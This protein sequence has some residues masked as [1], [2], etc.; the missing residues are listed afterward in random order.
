MIAT[1]RLTKR[2]GTR[3]ALDS[4]TFAAPDGAITG[5]L[6][7]NGAGKTTTF[8]I[9]SGL[10]RADEG[11]VEIGDRER[12]RRHDSWCPAPRPRTLRPPDGSGAHQLLRRAAWHAGKTFLPRELAQLVDQLGLSD[13]ALT[14]QRARCQRASG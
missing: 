1:T 2:F 12:R 5:L 13:V 9:A 7:P 14:F 8:R 3:L 6:G 11:R 10:L 4:V